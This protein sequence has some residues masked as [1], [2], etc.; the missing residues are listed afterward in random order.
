[1]SDISSYKVTSEGVMHLNVICR[2]CEKNAV[3]NPTLGVYYCPI[4][5]YETKLEGQNEYMDEL[6]ANLEKLEIIV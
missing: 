2:V 3:F 6:V 5:G 4:H 1:M